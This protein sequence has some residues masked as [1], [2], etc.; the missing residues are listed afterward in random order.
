[1]EELR[2]QDTVLQAD[3][4]GR[5]IASI[6]A[7]VLC[8]VVI[9]PAIPLIFGTI[10]FLMDYFQ[11]RH[12]Q[13]LFNEPSRRNYTMSLIYGFVMMAVFSTPAL[14]VW[15]EP[16]FTA[17]LTAVIYLVATQM[18]VVLVRA[19]HRP[20]G[21]A[22]M[23]PIAVCY[24]VMIWL[25][26]Q[27]GNPDWEAIFGVAGALALNG[28]FVFA[29][30]LNYRL[31]RELAD[32]RLKAETAN[33]AKSQFL[34]AMSHEL[35]TPLNGII[36]TGQLIHDHPDHPEQK[37]RMQALL[38]SAKALQNIV[39]D[40]MDLT[41]VEQG[42][43][44]LAPENVQIR[45]E[46]RTL[47]DLYGSEVRD[48]LLTLHVDVDDQVPEQLFLDPI[49]LR[50]V[51]GNLISNAVKFTIVGSI[52]ITVT[53]HGE[54][55]LKVV[56][57]DTG[58][59]IPPNELP[60][61]FSPFYQQSDDIQPIMRRGTG[62]GLSICQDLVQLMG[63]DVSVVSVVDKGTTF[64]ITLPLTRPIPVGAPDASTD[65]GDVPIPKA[66]TTVLVVDDTPTN[67]MVTSAFLTLAGFKTF[68]A[69]SGQSALDALKVQDISV[70]LLDMN[71]PQMDGL[72]TFRR[73]RAGG[74]S[75]PVIALTAD[76]M[77]GD[78][79]RY[80]SEGL[81][82]YLSKPATQDQMACAITRVL[83]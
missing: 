79:A 3:F 61:I 47:T 6:A 56:V 51:V 10:Y 11:P 17:K 44:R 2:R 50:Q 81:D 83:A 38:R 18:H 29:M 57:A 23:F 7:F 39:D 62:L 13:S 46:L 45:E 21:L 73:I 5:G 43:V 31:T 53:R 42:R 36:G 28:Y 16:E 74:C 59:G 25:Y 76:A 60:H 48:R 9:G 33:E 65:A 27:D 49:R 72:E 77:H 19:S 32:A 41:R 34:S 58:V 35:R 71:M 12:F 63:G 75:V 69:R 66:D 67:L 68:E 22:N 64:T 24:F 82:G 14:F 26:W 1:M 20:F 37:Q 70:V 30:L 40:V 15:V 55:K 54:N 52:T 78:E 4:L 8:A 80:L